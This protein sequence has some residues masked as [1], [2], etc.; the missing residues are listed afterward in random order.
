MLRPWKD[1]QWKCLEHFQR[2]IGIFLSGQHLGISFARIS[3]ILADWK[4]QSPKNKQ[5]ELYQ[6]QQF[7]QNSHPANCNL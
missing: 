2:L 5:L 3:E 7:R 4:K 1:C 6:V